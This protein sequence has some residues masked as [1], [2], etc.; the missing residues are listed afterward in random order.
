[1]L[2]E[3]V[4]L[5]ITDHAFMVA[6]I[7]LSTCRHILRHQPNNP[8]FTRMALEYQQ[9]CV[10]ALREEVGAAPSTISVMS[11]AKAVALGIDEVSL[12]QG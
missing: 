5:A 12:T 8:V 10:H 9:I 4:G 2:R 1:M 7:L 3:W 6:A 11:V